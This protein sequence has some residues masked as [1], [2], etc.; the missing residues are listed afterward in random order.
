MLRSIIIFLILCLNISHKSYY[1]IESDQKTEAEKYIMGYFNVTDSL[2][3]VK[4]KR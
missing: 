1:D 2:I 4:T 3:K